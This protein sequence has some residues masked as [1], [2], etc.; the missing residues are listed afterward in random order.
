[1]RLGITSASLGI[2]HVLLCILC[3]ILQHQFAILAVV[4]AY[5]VRD[6]DRVLKRS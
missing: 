6:L 3:I 2:I 4:Q 5:A 1:M